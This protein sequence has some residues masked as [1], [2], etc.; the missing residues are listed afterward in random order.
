[1]KKFLSLLIVFAAIMTPAF[2][3]LF[4]LSDSTI[5]FK[6]K[7]GKLLTKEEVQQLMK[8]TFSIRQEYGNGKKTITILPTG[9]DERA[10]QQAKIEAFRSNLIN[11]PLTAFKFKTLDG[12][13]LNSKELRGKVI[14]INFWFTGCKPCILEM[15]LLNELVKSYSDSAVVFIAP[16]P[17]NEM[18]IKKFLEKYRFEYN[19][20][21]S[22]SDFID[23]LYIENFPTHIVIDQRGVVRQ[24]FI[25]YSGDI[26]TKLKNE[27]DSLQQ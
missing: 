23:K 5:S 16:A 7:E 18:Q 10:L 19:I 8:G 4:S 27:I 1:M 3:Q 13:K 14:V 25:G 11:R 22:S 24:V 20:I 17:E 9:S 2:G 15:P 21:P 12:K 26:N 6:D